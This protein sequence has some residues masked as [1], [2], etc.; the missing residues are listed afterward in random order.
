MSGRQAVLA[1]VLAVAAA[2]A[3]AAPSASAAAPSASVLVVPFDLE[4][5]DQRVGWLSEGVSVGVTSALAARGVD[6]VTREERLAALERLQLPP[7][8]ALTRATLIKVAELVGATRVVMGS[9]RE[10]NGTVTIVSR[11]LDVDEAR[12]VE[13]PPVSSPASR[14]FDAFAGIVEHLD[15]PPATAESRAAAIAP[16]VPAFE[17]YVRGLVA[18]T[19]QTQEALLAQ[20]L[21]LAPG[22]PEPRRALWS[23]LTTRGAHEAALATSGGISGRAVP[24]GGAAQ[25]RLRAASSLVQLRRYDE[26][27]TQLSA[28]AAVSR[29]VA[30]PGLLGVVQLRRGSTPQTGRGTYYFNQVV[31]RDPTN[32]DACF[33]LGYAYWLDKDALAAAYWLREA[34]RR[35]PA[36]GDAHFVLAAALAASGGGPESARERELAR[37]LSERWEQ[38]GDSAAVPRGLE[39]LPEFSRPASAVLESALSAGLQR[40][41]QALAAFHLDAAARA[42]EQGRD[43]ETIRQTQRVLYLTPYDTTALRLLGRA[44][45]RSGLLQDAISAFKIALWS[46]ESAGAHVEL[47]EL[48]LRAHDPAGALKAAERAL[49]LEPDDAA[50]ADLA[51]RARQARGGA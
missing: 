38:A 2:T 35:D 8:A 48:L 1:V 51:V 49:A 13:L 25:W 17:L 37:R 30:V 40:D 10:A 46:A 14:L 39:R 44:Q 31:E 32:A 22:Y 28:L 7:A 12:L 6:V 50:A 45:A 19:P 42:F 34:V 18:S 9:V 41:Q 15:P 11:R 4:R 16:S 21:A 47:G 26:A 43:P 33:N 23:A 20:A 29:D 36:D 27:F 3:A 5:F 24:D